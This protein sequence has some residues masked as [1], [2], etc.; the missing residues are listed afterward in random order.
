VTT[1]MRHLDAEGIIDFA[2][3]MVPEAE[4]QRMLAHA[5]S[6]ADCEAR[7]LAALG[8]RE[9]LR[10]SRR[11]APPATSLS[12]PAAPRAPILRRV[13]PLALAAIVLIVAIARLGPGP[14]P[15]SVAWW[16]PATAELL[17][18]R[19]GHPADADSLFW[20]GLRAYHERDTRTAIRAFEQSRAAG[21]F[22]DLRRL[23]LASL[24]LHAG[25]PADTLKGLAAIPVDYL[26]EPWKG[27]AHWIE[28]LALDA[29][30]RDRQARQCLTDLARR[31][32]EFGERA[33][34]ELQ[35]TDS[36]TPRAR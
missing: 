2:M 33:R 18:L 19:D 29:L 31:A 9:R 17:E 12:K 14:T 25:R 34:E 13:G 6:C 27:N 22:E 21:G 11:R 15:P 28:Y 10:A 3:G 5:R 30:G 4:R 7:L 23:Y 20:E 16:L 26:P 32:D 24:H 8:D 35:R 36:G 1:E